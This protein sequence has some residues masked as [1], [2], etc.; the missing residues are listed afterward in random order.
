MASQ[1]VFEFE[2]LHLVVGV[3]LHIRGLGLEVVGYM[4]GVL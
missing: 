3:G 2:A 4:M 1:I